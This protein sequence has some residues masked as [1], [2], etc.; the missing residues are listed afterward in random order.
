MSTGREHRLRPAPARAPQLGGCGRVVQQAT[1]SVRQGPR[2]AR[3]DEEP[4]GLV[5]DEFRDS[6]VAL[7]T[8]GTPAAIPSR[9]ARGWFS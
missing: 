8:T 7:A 3:R 4:V 6:A 9:M 1:Q 2:V 5:L